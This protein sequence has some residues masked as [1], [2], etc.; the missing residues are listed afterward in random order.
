MSLET[1][2]EIHLITRDIFI[3]EEKSCGPREEC[4]FQTGRFP[5]LFNRASLS[6]M[7]RFFQGSM[8][9][10]LAGILMLRKAEERE[11]RECPV[12]LLSLRV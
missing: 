6:G 8:S 5:A 7:K 10:M 12:F 3:A 1:C 4:K 11:Q 2:P 9:A